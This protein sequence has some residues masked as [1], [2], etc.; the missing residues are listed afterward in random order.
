MRFKLRKRPD[1]RVWHRSFAWRPRWTTDGY[2]LWLT[3]GWRRREYYTY[4]TAT[5]WRAYLPLKEVKKHAL[6]ARCCAA[7]AVAE[8]N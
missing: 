7:C 3:W 2:V 6:R 8:A 4:D 5:M 1:D